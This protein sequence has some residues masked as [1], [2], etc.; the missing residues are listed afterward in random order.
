M[1]SSKKIKLLSLKNETNNLALVRATP[2]NTFGMIIALLR[3]YYLLH[4]HISEGNWD[5]YFFKGEELFEKKVGIV[6]FGRV[7]RRVA[8][9]CS[10]FDASVI[11]Y[12]IDNS[13]TCMK[14]DRCDSLDSLIKQSDIVVLCASVEGK[15]YII[16]T[17]QMRLFERKYFINTS[18]GELVNEE[19][20]INHIKLGN[21]KGVALDVIQNENNI[22]QFIE[23][24]KQ[25]N[26]FISP[27]ISGC[28]NESMQKTEI[29]LTKCL[30]DFLSSK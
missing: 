27:H 4:S 29:H 9:Y 19:E 26:V 15:D 25:H 6:G 10:A 28:T 1:L 8:H 30:R 11:W 12:D 24:A 2:E 13:I 3:R 21:F 5:R 17:D 7:G 23:L 14:H 18:R 20:M 22:I 16:D